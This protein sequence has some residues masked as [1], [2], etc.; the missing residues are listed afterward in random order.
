LALELSIALDHACHTP[1][2]A[3]DEALAGAN[4]I[5]GESVPFHELFGCESISDREPDYRLAG[6][7]HVH[8][9][10]RRRERGDAV[11]QETLTLGQ[12]EFSIPCPGCDGR[13]AS[14]PRS[15]LRRD[16][17]RRTRFTVP[18]DQTVSSAWQ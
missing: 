16:R 9:R 2:L 6:T 10:W 1:E 18:H 5:G 14:G 17:E 12:S 3:H 7:H 11:L 15:R 4:S 8:H 13:D